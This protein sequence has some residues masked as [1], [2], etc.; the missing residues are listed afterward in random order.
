MSKSI[1]C[2]LGISTYGGFE[3]KDATLDKQAAHEWLQT[4]TAPD[5]MAVFKRVD[6]NLV[7]SS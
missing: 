2:I 7:R 6:W 5:T 4:E 1:V 3:A